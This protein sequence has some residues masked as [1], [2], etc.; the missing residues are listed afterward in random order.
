M[1]IGIDIDNVIAHTFRD[2]VK[3]FNQYMGKEHDTISTLE[4]MRREKWK[5]L[6]YWVHTWRKGLLTLVEPVEEAAESIRRWYPEHR[7]SL[8]TSRL[9]IFNRQTRKWLKKHNIPFH[10]LH[11]AAE[12]TKFK[13]AKGCDIFIED[14]LNECEILADHCPKV[15]LIDHPWNR[16]KLVRPNIIRVKSWD[17]INKD[18]GPANR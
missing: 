5:V 9:T 17:E 1:K 13:K 7:I 4:A 8:I 15:Y 18:F 10:E 12:R 2:L 11:H 16:T 14:N 3:H 6:R